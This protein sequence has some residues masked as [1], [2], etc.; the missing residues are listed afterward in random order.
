MLSIFLIHQIQ[1][2]EL[3]F[4]CHIWGKIYSVNPTVRLEG[5]SLSKRWVGCDADLSSTFLLFSIIS[6]TKY[7][8][9]NTDGLLVKVGHWDWLG[10]ILHVYQP[11][12][13]WMLIFLKL[14]ALCGQP[15]ALAN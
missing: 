14:C 1:L 10:Y 5:G 8:I 3:L 12:Q 13:L 9:E 11:N 15:I 7:R 6:V 4:E 2:P